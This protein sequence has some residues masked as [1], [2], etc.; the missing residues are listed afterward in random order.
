MQVDLN[1]ATYQELMDLA[2]ASQAQPMGALLQQQPGVV[3]GR[4][5]FVTGDALL[6]ILSCRAMLR[7]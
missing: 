2:I 4:Q 3:P 7:L 5:A 1:M 6:K